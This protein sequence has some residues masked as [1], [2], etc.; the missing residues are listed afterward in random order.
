V[1]KFGSGYLPQAQHINI[2]R[3]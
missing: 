2:Y 1:F 3:I